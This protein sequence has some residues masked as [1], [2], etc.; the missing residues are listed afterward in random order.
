VANA[1]IVPAGGGG[2]VNAYASNA[3]DLI[4]DI[5][6]YFVDANRADAYSFYPLTPCRAVDTRNPNGPLGGPS[7][8]TIA[9]RTFPLL[10]APCAIPSTSRAYSLNYTVVPR[11]PLGYL[12]TWP[13]GQIQPFVSTLNS[14]QGRVLANAA[15]V[16]AG[17]SGA[18]SA[19]AFTDPSTP[20]DLVIDVNGH[21]APPSPGGLSFY[22][23]TPCRVVDTR[24][25]Q[26]TTGE[27]GPPSI[28]R[29]GT[30][31]FTLPQS[32]C[33]IPPFAA[34]YS[35]NVTVVPQGPL[36]YLTMWPT[37]VPQPFVSTLNAPDGRILANAAIVPAGTNGAISVY[38][39]TESA[40]T[41]V[42]IDVNGYF[43]P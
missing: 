36:S 5:N 10:S 35:L 33:V 24:F 13:A 11:G 14:P 26:G 21:F 27:F 16:P 4:L 31:T 25:G 38:V 42:I 12:S 29:G 39:L 41:D 30:R 19:F 20:T 32:P 15:I 43:A 9:S 1:A 2:A 28:P 6:G 8:S 18:V 7:L 3:T 22:P 34:A 40:P 17:A 23:M 37:G